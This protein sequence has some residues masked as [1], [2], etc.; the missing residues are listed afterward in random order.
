MRKKLG[1]ALGGGGAKGFAHIGILQVLHENNI[2]PD[3][4]AGTSMGAAIGAAYCAGRSPKEIALF[5]KKTNLVKAIDFNVP[6]KGLI[7]GNLM[8]ETLD[9]LVFNKTFSAL[10]IPLAV[11]AF[12]LTTNEI[13]VFKKGAVSNAVRASMSIPGV[14]NPVFEGNNVY[15]DGAIANPTPFDIVKEMGADVV[16]AIDLYS[17]QRITIS[18]ASRDVKNKQTF[19]M[20][21]KK[22]FVKDQ[23]TFLKLALFPKHWPK[24]LRKTLLWVFDRLIYPARV[25]GLIKKKQKSQFSIFKT[26]NQSMIILMN[27]LAKE[28]LKHG[29]ID[30]I[31]KPKFG[32]LG[33]TDFDKSDKIVGIG[34]RS[35]QSKM[36]ELKKLL[37]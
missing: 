36:S 33:W 29:E 32:N 7:S 24:L 6:K 23:I 31:V 17:D 16:L 26:L 37:R 1:I 15:V 12:N 30:L 4:I 11:V 2:F 14:F 21:M 34:R 10:K 35:M 25:L 22:K 19:M 5:V 13:I 27:N 18:K 28:R 8:Q 20:Q 3:F 9:E